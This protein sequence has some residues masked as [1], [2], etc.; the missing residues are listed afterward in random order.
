[1]AAREPAMTPE[2]GLRNVR[3]AF[4]AAI[5]LAVAGYAAAPLFPAP[6]QANTTATAAGAVV[7]AAGRYTLDTPIEQIAATPAGEA[8]L[9]RDMPGLLQHRSYPMFKSM[10]LRL[11]GR[12]S[13]G[14]M[15]D[16]DLA[17]T[18]RDLATLPPPASPLRQ[19][20]QTY[21]DPDFN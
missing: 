15:S 19:V 16:T 9:N 14:R 21:A 10:S 8:I 12:L 2:T 11:V 13:G 6:A 18:A 5:F 7:N 3:L 1:M 20:S 4:T 17:Q